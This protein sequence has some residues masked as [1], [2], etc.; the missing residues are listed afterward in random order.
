MP[1]RRDRAG[2]AHA[3]PSTARSRGSMTWRP[4]CWAAVPRRDLRRRGS[5]PPAD[6]VRR[7][8]RVA[9]RTGGLAQA[10]VDANLRGA[11]GRMRGLIDANRAGSA[12]VQDML[13]QER[14]L[15]QPAGDPTRSNAAGACSTGWLRPTRRP[16]S[17]STP[18][19]SPAY[20]RWRR[21]RSWSC[22]I[23]SAC[24]GPSGDPG[25]RLRDPFPRRRRSQ[26]KSPIRASTSRPG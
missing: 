25:Y 12:L 15:A 5:H 7:P 11:I 3:R 6:R 8:G 18:S 9:R 14:V 17:P 16:A 23:G 13:R 1:S 10:D 26:P 19:A 4:T 20:W 2:L 21:S 24:S 22:S